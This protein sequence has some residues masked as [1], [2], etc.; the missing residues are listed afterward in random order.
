MLRLHSILV[1]KAWRPEYEAAGHMVSTGKQREMVLSSFAFFIQSGT[2]AHG[3]VLPTVSGE[4]GEVFP[5]M[6]RV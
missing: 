2:P 3:V 5:P 4:K 6:N 1:G